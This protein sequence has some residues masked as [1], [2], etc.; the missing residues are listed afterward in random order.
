MKLA[1]EKRVSCRVPRARMEELLKT[2]L[3]R[4]GPGR[5]K[6]VSEVSLAFVGSS[7]MKKL[8]N[9]YRGKNEPTDVLSFEYGEV[10]VCVPVAERQAKE[11]K[12]TLNDEFCL[13]FTHGVLHVLGYDHEK[14]KDA[15]IMRSAEQSLLGFD[16]LITIAHR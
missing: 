10:I 5:L 14:P 12:M 8:N 1:I 15:A 16:G 6:D 2:T 9:T 4:Y 11:H 3:R 7:E 13:L